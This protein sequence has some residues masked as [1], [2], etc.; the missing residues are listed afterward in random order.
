MDVTPKGIFFKQSED[1][2]EYEGIKYKHVDIM[3]NIFLAKTNTLL[4][5]PWDED[6]KLGGHELY[7]WTLKNNGIK[8]YWTDNIIFQ[9]VSSI[10]SDEYKT[11]RNRWADQ[12][13]LALKKM[14]TQSWVKYPKNRK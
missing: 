5:V 11:Y 8:C 2:I 10:V 12:L 6:L 3:R 9:R 13:K 14:E 4:K 7:F 1:F